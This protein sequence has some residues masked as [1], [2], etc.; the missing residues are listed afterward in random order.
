MVTA[1]SYWDIQS[2][3]KNSDISPVYLLFG[4]EL[5]LKRTLTEAFR[6]NVLSDDNLADFNY[7]IYFAEDIEIKT[8]LDIA[9]TQPFL[10][11][12]RLLIIR[13]AEKLS[14]AERELVVY[15]SNPAS[16][17]CL[18]LDS[19]KHLSNKFLKRISE[20][21]VPVEI[22]PR[23]GRDLDQWIQEYVSRKQKKI[24]QNASY[25]LAEKVGS[26]LD[27]LAGALD[28]ICL[29][30]DKKPLIS[31]AV[32]EEMV[33]KTKLDSRFVFLDA[34]AD[35]NA[36]LALPLVAPL[37]RE[38]KDAAAM[39]GLINSRLKQIEN[40]KKLKSGGMPVPQIASR[41]SLSRYSLSRVQR[42]AANFQV[43][44]LERNFQLLLD[45]DVAI[46]T[47]Q[48]SP[49]LTLETLVVR[50]CAR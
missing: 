33:S 31:E 14:A 21:T 3:L 23:K 47:G 43:K 34:L 30:L 5:Y 17:T 36:A 39:I 25:L 44:E 46:K 29:Y 20:H 1:L 10:G 2:K 15:L 40:F 41:L 6:K 12:K 50:L 42:Q 38:G 18:I 45:S 19:D 8:V 32:V 7:G 28:K 4:E 27:L 49:V 26:E 11:K 16:W 22:S 37:S 48:S 9:R 35:K 24:G 13:N